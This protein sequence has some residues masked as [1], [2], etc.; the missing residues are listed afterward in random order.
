MSQHCCNRLADAVQFDCEMHS[1][2]FECPDA[3]VLRGSSGEY[4][5][6]VH[7]GGS[8]YVQ[9]SHCPWCGA[10]LSADAPA[11]TES[12]YVLQHEYAHHGHSDAKMLGVFS[13]RTS[14][15]EAAQRLALQ[16][17]FRDYPD[18]FSID[19]YEIDRDHWSEGFR[20]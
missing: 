11:A 15:S 9:I 8:S 18:G 3:L 17:G 12:V 10:R 7:D 19:E 5:L 1:N 6:V 14:A 20:A 16:P 13:S 4:G 2:P